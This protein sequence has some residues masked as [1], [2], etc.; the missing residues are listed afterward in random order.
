MKVSLFDRIFG[1]L[2][3]VWLG[4]DRTQKINMSKQIEFEKLNGRGNYCSWKD[5]ML[6]FLR[7]RDLGACVAKEET[8]TEAKALDKARGW[9]HLA[10]EPHVAN[11]FTSGMTPLEV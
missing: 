11:H 9:L 2:L 3:K 6:A 10:V 4:S 8:E 5:N 7:T 1:Q